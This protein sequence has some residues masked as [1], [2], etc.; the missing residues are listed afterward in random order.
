MKQRFLSFR[1]KVLECHLLMKKSKK[2]ISSGVRVPAA[3]KQLMDEH[4]LT[5]QMVFD[6]ALYELYEA[7]LEERNTTED[8]S[9]ILDT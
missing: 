1:T 9:Q 5:T 2:E 6:V 7:F 4:G 3:L 8:G